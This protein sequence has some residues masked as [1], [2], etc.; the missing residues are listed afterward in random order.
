MLAASLL[1]YTTEYEA[2]D[3]WEE[4]MS[5]L[6]NRTIA[7]FDLQSES[8]DIAE[9]EGKGEATLTVFPQYVALVV[10]ITVQ[11][12]FEKYRATSSWDFSASTF[13]GWL[14]FAII[15]GLVLFPGAYRSAFNP[16]Q[17]RFVQFCVIF[18]VG[19][20]WKSLLDTGLKVSQAIGN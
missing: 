13:F 14:V 7:Y 9:L 6:L 3:I 16:K 10:G 12:Y 19:M 15:T 2:S 11:P 1:R 8:R 17:P 20:G 4:K 5:N 18:T